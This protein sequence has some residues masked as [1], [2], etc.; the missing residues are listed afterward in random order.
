ML[1]CSPRYPTPNVLRLSYMRS[2]V[3]DIHCL[4]LCECSPL[5]DIR[6]LNLCM[7]ASVRHLTLKL[8][9]SSPS[10]D[11]QYLKLFTLDVRQYLTPIVRMSVCQCVPLSVCLLVC[12]TVRQ[13]VLL[14]KCVRLSVC[15]S[16]SHFTD[17]S[18]PV[19]LSVY[20]ALVCGTC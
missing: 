9:E 5:S 16:D 2:P 1:G 20:T 13:C 18:S 19:I 8:C 14:F 7:F 17:K 3:S 12:V 4:K 10:S 6:C 11:T 15:V